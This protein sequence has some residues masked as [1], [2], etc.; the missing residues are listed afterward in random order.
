MA[1]QLAASRSP[2]AYA[3]VLAYAHGHPG[4]GASAAYLALGHAYMQDHR[5]PEA[6]ANLTQA[7]RSGEALAD[8]ADYLTAQS[9]I[10]SG[11]A[12]DAYA[13]LD[14]FAD[15]YPDSIFA[16]TA[17]VLLAT[18]HLQQKCA[19]QLLRRYRWT[20]YLQIQPLELM[21]HRRQS[22]FRKL[23]DTPQRVLRRNPFP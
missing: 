7:K 3:G 5:T 1:Q 16:A 9:D 15:R 18:A 13:L 12:A 2:A 4:E 19:Q 6:I 22:A 17:P 21:R 8:Y 14:R 10:Q 11:H 20:A 23:T